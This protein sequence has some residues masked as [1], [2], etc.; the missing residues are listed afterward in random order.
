MDLF[1]DTRKMGGKEFSSIYK[2]QLQKDIEEANDNFKSHNE[3]KNIFSSA[4]T[5]AV[6]F[7]VM[8][9]AYFLSGFFGIIGIESFASLMN[10]ALGIFLILLI[11]WIYCRY[12]GDHA[13]IGQ[14]IDQ[15]ANVIWDKVDCFV[16]TV[17]FCCK[18]L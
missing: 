1:D 8:A 10:W 18:I 11:T 5:P 9:I 7:S 12:S 17:H 6:L 2:E 14:H 15:V 13:S 3:G 4:R 16:T